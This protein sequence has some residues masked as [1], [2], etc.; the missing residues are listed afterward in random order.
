MPGEDCESVLPA[1]RSHMLMVQSSFYMGSS[2]NTSL[3]YQNLRVLK[4]FVT[5]DITFACNPPVPSG[6]LLDDTITN[7]MQTPHERVELSCLRN[8][9]Q[10]K[11]AHVPA[12]VILFSVIFD[13]RLVESECGGQGIEAHL[14][15]AT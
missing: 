14:C 15:A 9:E 4:S 6:S 13:S 5:N 7:A 10:H 1:L 2:V 3:G 11:P 8:T 12:G